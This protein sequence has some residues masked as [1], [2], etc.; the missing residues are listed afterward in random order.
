[1]RVTVILLHYYLY[2]NT[3]YDEATTAQLVETCDDLCGKSHPAV[4]LGHPVGSGEHISSWFECLRITI[5]ETISTGTATRTGDAAE[6][7][8]AQT[9]FVT[10]IAA[11]QTGL[12]NRR[13][14]GYDK[15]HH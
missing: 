15:C 6:H 13:R 3:T 8:F 11:W 2:A 1:M 14:F 4:G 5:A 7:R 10:D 12:L 9:A